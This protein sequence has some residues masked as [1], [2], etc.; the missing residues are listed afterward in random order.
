MSATDSLRGTIRDAPLGYILRYVINNRVFRHPEEHAEFELPAAWNRIL[1]STDVRTAYHTGTDTPSTIVSPT[2]DQNTIEGLDL[3]SKGQETTVPTEVT[4]NVTENGVILV[5]RSEIYS[6]SV[7][8]VMEKFGVSNLEATLGLA[9][10]VL[11]YGIG[12]LLFSPLGEIPYIG[13]NPV[14]IITF[15]IFVII[16]IPTALVDSFSGLIVVRFLQGFLGSPCLASG[17][18]S[19]GD[20]Y[21]MVHMPLAMIAWV[22]AMSCGPSLG[23]LI[24]AYAVTAKGW[25]WSLYESIWVWAPV[26]IA[27]F[28]FMPET[29]A[30]IL[31]R[32][33]ERLRRYAGSQ[34]LQ[35]Q[36]EIDQAHLTVSGIAVEALIKPLEIIIKDPAVI[37]VQIYSG[38]L[39]AIYYS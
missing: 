24:S 6:P 18:A 11:G 13:R 7:E 4:P 33:A 17:G 30:P 34:R 26:L 19:L 3:E 27:L 29:R 15:A 38:I 5:D 14:Y 22:G 12:L 35:S 21:G 10:Y 25:R 36:S 39:H 1:N 16:S 37:F 20:M 32:R 31:F 9:M 23:P 8:G 2:S 28:I